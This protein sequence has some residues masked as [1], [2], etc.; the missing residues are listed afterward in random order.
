[1]RRPRSWGVLLLA[2]WLIVW[3][4]LTAPFLQFSFAYKGELLAA[5]AIVVGVFLILDR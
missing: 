2:I 4:L 5:F 3:G 1:M